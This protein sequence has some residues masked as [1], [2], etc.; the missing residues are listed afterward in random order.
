MEKEDKARRILMVQTAFLGDVV[1][2]TP[3]LLALKTRFKNSFLAFMGTP[4]GCGILE[5]L[6]FVD[7]FLVYDKKGAE[8]GPSGFLKKVNEIKSYEFDIAISAHRSA[9]TAALLK[10]AGIKR[11]IGFRTSD[12]PWLYHDRVPRDPAKHEVERNLELM[13]PLGGLP[14]GFEPGLSLPQ[15]SPASDDLLG[16]NGNGPR[17]GICPGSIWPTKRWRHEGFSRVADSLHERAATIYL[18]GSDADQE[19]ARA[20][21]ESSRSPIKNL[22]GRTSLIDWLRVIAAMDLVITNDSAPVHVASALG[23]P[24]VMI[25]GPTTRDQGF[26]PRTEFCR[27]V[28]INGLACRPCGEHGAKRCPEGHGKCMELIRPQMVLDAARELLAETSRS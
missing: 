24:V 14:P 5:G 9:R 4:S 26:T 8:S 6:A 25:Y 11:R 1:L 28:E 2:A 23:V 19:A 17:V 3:L 20:V 7:K 22:V 13:G 18:L 21:R 15:L 27:V 10:M 12:L 16:D